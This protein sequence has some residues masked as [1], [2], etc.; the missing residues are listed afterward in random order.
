MFDDLFSHAVE[1]VPRLFDRWDPTYGYT[2]DAYV[3]YTLRLYLI[4]RSQW[5]MRRHARQ[6]TLEA[7]RD[8]G[9]EHSGFEDTDARDSVSYIRERLPAALWHVLWMHDGLGLTFKD[10]GL[11]TGVHRV[12]IGAR[13]RRAIAAAREVADGMAR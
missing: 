2:L 4:K 3:R 6:E 9:D 10:I 1:V 13:Y 8:R 7:I 5:I 12:V 11:L